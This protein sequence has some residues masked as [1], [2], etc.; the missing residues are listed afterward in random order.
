MSKWIVQ[1]GYR[2]GKYSN[3]YTL[4]TEREAYFWFNGINT[5]SGYKK[6]LISP[7]GKVVA[8]VTT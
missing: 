4:D 2:K 3:R 6:R 1:D 5:H 7:A 8:R